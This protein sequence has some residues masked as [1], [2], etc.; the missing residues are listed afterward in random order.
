MIVVVGAIMGYLLIVSGTNAVNYLILSNRLGD[1]RAQNTDFS[2]RM[3]ELRDAEEQ[4]NYLINKFEYIDRADVIVH[5]SN[6]L[7]A[8]VL[9]VL[10]YRT[11]E[12]VTISSANLQGSTFIM[13]GR[14]DNL[15]VLTQFEHNIRN[16]ILFYNP[17]IRNA[18]LMLH[19]AER[20]LLLLAS[21]GIEFTEEELRY[22]GPYSF[23]MGTNILIRPQLISETRLDLRQVVE[24]RL[25]EGN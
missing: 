8:M 13:N 1:L 25:E 4:L 16:S 2:V 15:V 10:A 19:P 11:P 9:Q 14:A 3:G 21:G 7:S 6:V 12:E 18:N 20:E 23:T 5:N 22:I 24:E 17:I